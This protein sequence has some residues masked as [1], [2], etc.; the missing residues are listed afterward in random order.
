V[1][2]NEEMRKDTKP[3]R[4]MIREEYCMGCRLCEV[5][6]ITEHSKSKD[7]I[8]TYKGK[9][10][11]PLSGIYFEE[12][13]YTSFAIQCRHCEEP[14]CV[15]ACLTGAMYKDEK[16]GKVLHNSDK[17]VGCWMCIMVCPFGVIKPDK[18]EKKVA[19]KCDLCMEREFPVCVEK[20]PNEAIILVD[21][22]GRK[23]EKNEN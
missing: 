14:P 17:C 2:K 16:T 5:Y 3:G 20:C 13:G 10:P 12:R 18:E 8:K 19:S 23:I 11:L 7:I 21:H 22:K 9:H 6:C 15:E 4:I 1:K